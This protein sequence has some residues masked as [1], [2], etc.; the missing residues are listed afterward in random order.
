MLAFDVKENKFFIDNKPFNVEFKND[1]IACKL[2]I[3][4]NKRYKIHIDDQEVTES[5]QNQALKYW[6][7][8]FISVGF[9]KK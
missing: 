1:K 9:L 6:A 8:Q 5:N 3:L 7:L 4:E 2:T